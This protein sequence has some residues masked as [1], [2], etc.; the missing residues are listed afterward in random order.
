MPRGGRSVRP[1][2]I[3]TKIRAVTFYAQ[4][5]YNSTKQNLC[6]AIFQKICIFEIYIIQLCSLPF[7]SLSRVLSVSGRSKKCSQPDTDGLDDDP[8][9]EDHSDIQQDI[10]RKEAAAVLD[11]IR[12]EEIMPEE[13]S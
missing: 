11:G 13:R 10:K 12:F 6:K 1:Q 2:S 5:L 3:G 7:E 4:L 9:Q 8:G